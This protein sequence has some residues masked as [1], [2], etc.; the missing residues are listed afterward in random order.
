MGK[1][2]YYVSI[3]L[4]KSMYSIPRNA[5]QSLT[6]RWSFPRLADFVPFDKNIVFHRGLG[7]ALW[8][9]TGVHVYG[10]DDVPLSS[11]SNNSNTHFMSISHVFIRPGKVG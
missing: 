4:I 10:F 2:P 11:R 5:Y 1:V 6:Y 9:G 3:P 7:F 8:I